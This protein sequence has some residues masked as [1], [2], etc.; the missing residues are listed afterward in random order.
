MAPR[1]PR[2]G[3]DFLVLVGQELTGVT[4]E[5]GLSP[6]SRSHNEEGTLLPARGGAGRWSGHWLHTATGRPLGQGARPCP[7]F[8]LPVHCQCLLWTSLI[9]LQSVQ[10]KY[11]LQ[12]PS[13]SITKQ[14]AEGWDGCGE[15]CLT[16]STNRPYVESLGVL[17]IC[18]RNQVF[19]LATYKA[20]HILCEQHPR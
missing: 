12:S 3:F 19:I 4:A 1:W 14:S 7:F 15:T 10:E 9:A 11:S 20:I 13:A 5:P 16:A 18:Y 8:C 2:R 6:L 17:I